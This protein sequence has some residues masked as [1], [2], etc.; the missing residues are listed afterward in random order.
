MS[1]RLGC[2]IRRSIKKK[3]K[4]I[5]LTMVNSEERPRVVWLF[6][7]FA[8]YISSQEVKCLVSAMARHLLTGNHFQ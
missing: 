2:N 6:L 3:K 4:N 7:V 5:L 8:R 1:G